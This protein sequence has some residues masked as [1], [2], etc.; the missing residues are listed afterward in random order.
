MR[1]KFT[2][3]EMSKIVP[4]VPEPL[5][6][7]TNNRFVCY[8]LAYEDAYNAYKIAQSCYWTSDEI[9]LSTDVTD[10]NDKL[11]DDERSTATKILSFFSVFDGLINENLILRFSVEVQS[12]EHRAFYTFQSAIENVHGETYALLMQTF[13]SDPE[14]REILFNAMETNAMVKLKAEW[15][16][17]H[18]ISQDLEFEQRQVAFACVEGIFFS[19]SFLFIYWLKKR[20][21]MP[22]LCQA[23]E[24]IARDEGQHT[25]FAV[26]VHN[27][28]NN[29]CANV[30]EIVRQAVELECAFARDC[31]ARPLVGLNADSVCTYVKFIADRLLVSLHQ[32]KVFKVNNPFEWMERISIDSK[33]NFFEKRNSSYSVAHKRQKF[34]IKECA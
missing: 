15:T 18:I 8:P 19:S 9:D 6:I 24:L 3:W 10:W 12:F 28:L 16:L 25:D 14:Q 29:K 11:N 26:M 23:N 30:E 27:S 33:A 5:L 21:L 4:R 34:A 7:P 2:T 32:P 31:Y 20:S 22:G 1:R 17:K 13:I